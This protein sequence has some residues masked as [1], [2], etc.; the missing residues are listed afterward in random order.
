MLTVSFP[1]R[2]KNVGIPL[3]LNTKDVY[4]KRGTILIHLNA[5]FLQED[6]SGKTRKI[7]STINSS[8][9]IMPSLEYLC[10]ESECSFAKYFS[11]CPNTKYLYQRL[12]LFKMKALN[13]TESIFQFLVRYGCL[14]RL[15]IKRL[16]ACYLLESLRF[17]MF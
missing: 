15:K 4:E 13:A 10:L 9:L 5:D 14:K 11:L 3:R 1:L 7:L 2:A 8:I 17:K 6:F 12:P 16:D